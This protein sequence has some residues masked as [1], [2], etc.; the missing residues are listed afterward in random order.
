[1]DSD[2]SKIADQEATVFLALLLKAF[3]SLI[4]SPVITVLFTKIKVFWSGSAVAARLSP[5]SFGLWSLC[6]GGSAEG[7]VSSQLFLNGARPASGL[8]PGGDLLP[9]MSF[10]F[11]G[12]RSQLSAVA[13]GFLLRVFS[14]S[15]FFSPPAF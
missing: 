1:V 13:L 8:A 10:L 4:S 2:V 11:L 9:E 12:T 15:Y 3:V 7:A 6:C 14:F 5:E